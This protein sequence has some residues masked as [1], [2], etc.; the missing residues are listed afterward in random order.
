M[1]WMFN[2]AFK[3]FEKILVLLAVLILIP[4]FLEASAEETGFV[5]QVNVDSLNFREKP[6]KAGNP[7][8]MLRKGD[9]VV[10][11][12]EENGWYKIAHQDRVGYIKAQK[13]YI[14]PAEGNGGKGAGGNNAALERMLKESKKISSQ[15]EKSKKAVTDMSEEEKDVISELD[16]IDASLNRIKI[17]IRE[18][19]VK[20]ED[21]DRNIGEAE[22]SALQIDGKLERQK[23]EADNRIIALY[24]LHR[25]G[26]I[27][28]LASTENLFDLIRKK[29][30]FERIL[31]NDTR[32]LAAYAG[33]LRR[34]HELLET[35]KNRKEEH[36][37]F[38][39][40]LEKQ[41]AVVSVEKQKRDKL[42]SRIRDQKHLAQASQKTLRQSAQKLEDKIKSYAAA[43]PKPSDV[44]NKVKTTKK[45]KRADS[46][47]KVIRPEPD[48]REATAEAP[49]ESLPGAQFGQLK[50][51]LKMPVRGKVISR[52][53]TYENPEFKITNFR[54][55]IDIRAE[56]G[57]PIKAVCSGKVLYSEWFKGYGNMII[58]DHGQ[59]YYTV[60]ANIE[61]L[62]KRTGDFVKSHEVIA[63][64]GDTGSIEGPK[65]YFEIRHHG[66]PL[67]PIKW[68][69][70]G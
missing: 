4:A 33:D 60:Y 30:G 45:K 54:S 53:G 34:H 25:M 43:L 68:I 29:N 31:E 21:L 28:L 10:I 38:Q 46:G 41:E 70:T 65:L 23:Q 62:F 47:Q 32:L 56:K 44:E 15:L 12:E 11:L 64:V 13:G 37:K 7:I 6:D 14:T 48:E 58:I 24:K 59:H 35:Q 3:I 20:L 8:K 27:S 22:Q 19:N 16:K 39:A 26:A 63:T 5:G 40:E 51:L 1:A 66:K 61:E 18:M 17:N 69:K 2:F 36:Q 52:F 42:L 57:E 67:N 9:P 49:P 55:G 50:G